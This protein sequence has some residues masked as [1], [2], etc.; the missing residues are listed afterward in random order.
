MVRTTS[1]ADTERFVRIWFDPDTISIQTFWS[2]T[3]YMDAPL[4]PRRWIAEG[5]GCEEG[6]PDESPGHWEPGHLQLGRS[7]ECHDAMWFELEAGQ[8]R[9]TGILKVFL[10]Q[11]AMPLN[12]MEQD[13]VFGPSSTGAPRI[14]ASESLADLRSRKA[15][16]GSWDVV[17]KYITIVPK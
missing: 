16:T 17:T 14:D 12:L 13:R 9:G 7:P 8:I 4:L 6:A 15:L 5:E 11:K 2:P 1:A 3:D 10:A